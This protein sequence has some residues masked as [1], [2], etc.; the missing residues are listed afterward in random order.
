MRRLITAAEEIAFLRG[1]AT[2]KAWA[3]RAYFQLIKHVNRVFRMR[4]WHGVVEES[5]VKWFW[6]SLGLVLC[7]VPVFVQLPGRL[8]KVADFGGRTEGFV[9]NRRLLLSSS[10]AMGKHLCLGAVETT[11]Y[12][13]LTV[14]RAVCRAAYVYLSRAERVVGLHGA[15][16]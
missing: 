16:V 2:E 9:T 10:D 13:R 5:I 7:S 3:D 4:F 14:G 1:E 8:G 15:G 6:G 12:S 11:S